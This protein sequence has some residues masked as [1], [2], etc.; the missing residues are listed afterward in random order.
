MSPS[1]SHPQHTLNT[2]S[3][4]TL[5]TGG[6]SRPPVALIGYGGDDS[7]TSAATSAGGVI[8]EHLLTFDDVKDLQ[9]NNA[10][11]LKVIRKLSQE[12]EMLEAR[13]R[14]VGSSEALVPFFGAEAGAM[15]TGM[16]DKGDP[17][18]TLALH[19]ALQELQSL[20][21][22]RQRT[23]ELVKTLVQQRDLYKVTPLP[24]PSSLLPP[25]AQ[26]YTHPIYGPSK[27]VL[28]LS[29]LIYPCQ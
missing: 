11:L 9:Q 17:S 25:T 10:K 29:Y 6:S 21:E 1:N 16:G 27:V 5:L 15:D 7:G 20:R 24:P 4:R 13:V 8:T 2:H 12:Q 26:L 22:T 23:E 19:T 28:F 18:T 14:T 3:Q